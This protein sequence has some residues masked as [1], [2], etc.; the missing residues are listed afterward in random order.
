MM[1]FILLPLSATLL[2]VPLLVNAAPE[3]H[4]HGHAGA[5]T[6]Q[7]DAG[8]KWATDDALRQGMDSIRALTETALPA[9]HAGTLTP[10]GYDALANDVN[11]QVAH[12]I[13]NC[14]LDARADAQLHIVIAELSD[15]IETMQ[16]KRAGEARAMG[17]VHVSETLN[18]YGEHFDHPGWKAIELPH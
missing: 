7:L 13:D 9:A 2:A 10:A 8:K 6:I 12:I 18:T 4:D 15:G 14:K 16:G 17:V 11:A 1:K 5:H 3:H